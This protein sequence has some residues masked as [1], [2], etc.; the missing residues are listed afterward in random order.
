MTMTSPAIDA[1]NTFRDTFGQSPEHLIQAPGRVNLIG[2]HTDYNDGFVFP[3]A[4]NYHAAIAATGT[5]DRTLDVIALNENATRASIPLDEPQVFDETLHW[6]N[7]VRG[8]VQE[9][10]AAGFN[11]AGGQLAIAGNVPLGAG[12]SSSAALEIALIRTLVTLGHESIDGKQAALIGQAAENRFVGCN[13]GI[14]DQLIS[15]LGERDKALLIDC[16]SLSTTPVSLP[17]GATILVIHSNVKRQLVD[18]EYNARR[19][20]CERVARHFG[21]A[22]LRD[23]TLDQLQSQQ[24]VLGD[25]EFRRARHVITENE[26]TLQMKSALVHADLQLAGRLMA[27]SHHSMQHDFEITVPE[28]DALVAMIRETLGGDGG[29]RMTGGGFGGCVVVLLPDE[30]VDAVIDTVNTRYPAVAGHAATIYRCRA[31]QGAFSD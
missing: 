25:V 18:G 28:I 24:G 1:A 20:E 7:Y 8:I 30:H 15:A 2:E 9:L 10:R 27:D 12:L 31:E 5:A 16:R 4:I 19:S 22:A 21:V 17:P 14:M 11:L 3:L 6:S 29:A 23:L 13:C 26:R